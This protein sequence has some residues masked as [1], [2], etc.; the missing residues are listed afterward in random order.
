MRINI[1]KS[2]S[3]CIVVTTHINII[4]EDVDQLI[5]ALSQIAREHG[6]EDESMVSPASDPEQINPIYK[7]ILLNRRYRVDIR[8]VLAAESEELPAL[9]LIQI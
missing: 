5:K 2:T 4:E 3:K 9:S 7:K 6:V 8:D 1:E